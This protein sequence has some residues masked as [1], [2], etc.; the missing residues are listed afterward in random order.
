[1]NVDAAISISPTNHGAAVLAAMAAYGSA[2]L[3]L[4]AAGVRSRRD[5]AGGAI[6]R[7]LGMTVYF[8]GFVAAVAAV[9]LRWIEVRHVPLRN[10]YEV[11]IGLGMLVFLLSVFS[12]RLLGVGGEAADALVGALVLVP[13][14][15]FL[16]PAPGTLPPA[17]RCPLFVPHVAAYSLAYVILAKAAIQAV[18]H[19]AGIGPKN[20]SALDGEQAAYRMVCLGFPLL[21]AGLILGSMWGK[22]AW[23]DY[24][25][26][27]PKELWSLAT[28]GVFLIYLHVRAMFG[29]RCKKLNCALI[30]AG[31]LA[32]LITLLWVN[33]SK[34]FGSSLHTYA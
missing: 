17:L 11:F 18:G 12:R 3:V 24:W 31:M 2:S 22:L 9:V 5:V 8:A 32:I 7:R 10:L 34:I 14:A 16:D 4:L 23:G 33:L 21:T 1:M 20:P 27:D 30:G 26:F 19:L 25:N 29:R 6:L 13:A 15:F 28:W